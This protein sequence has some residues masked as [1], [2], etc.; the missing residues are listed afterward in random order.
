MVFGAG[1]TWMHLIPGVGDDTLLSFMGV[2]THTYV[3]LFTGLACA[4][5]VLFSIFARL[6]LEKAKKRSGV[7][8]YFADDRLS[9]RNLAEML[10]EFWQG[11]MGD[12]LSKADVRVFL[13]FVAS[14]FLYIFTCNIMAIFPGFLPPTDYANT[15]VGVAVLVFLTF[16]A[17]GLWRDPIGYIKHLMGPV[18]FLAPFMFL[19]EC[20][21]LVVRPI[22]LYIRL[23]G[24][25]FG[26]HTVFNM[27]TDLSYGVLIPI[28]FLGL[29]ILVSTIQAFIFALLT[30]IYLSLS[31]P[32]EEHDEAH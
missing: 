8:R 28:P 31:V 13:P 26:D 5:L 2:D 19:V 10:V 16:N 12:V 22:A 1:F 3:F 18:L 30:T 20:I 27:M 7:E 29:A 23:T 4:V 32:H 25:M 21:S 24:N 9:V 17:V 15:S 11:P 6:G 14:L